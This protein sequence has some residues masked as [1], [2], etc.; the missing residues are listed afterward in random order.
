MPSNVQ[1][2]PVSAWEE[3]ILLPTYPVPAP[4]PNP[5]FLDKRVNQG[6][7]G[8]VYPNPFTDRLSNEKVERPY[9]AVF[10]ENEYLQLILLPEIGGRIFA[11]LDKTNGFNFFYR[12]HVIKPALIGLLGAWISG[13]VEF[14][15]PQHHR[16]STFMRVDH[17]IEEHPDGSRTVWLSDHEPMDRTRGMVGICLHPGR[18][19][20][21]F[22]VRL[23]NCTPF[24]Q[25]F[26]WWVNTAVH[27]HDQ[28]QVVFPPDVTAVTD[29]SKRA[30]CHFPVARGAYYGVD[31]TGVDIS[32][33]R[34]IPVAASYF[35]TESRYDFF[36]GYD[37]KHDAGV[38]HVADHHISPGKKMFTWGT[39][40]FG[41][42]WERN[43]TDADGPYIEL[44]AGMYTD[45]QPDFS[46]I[47]PY[48]RKTFSQFWYPVQ[49]IGPA[50]DANC[51]LAVNLETGDRSARVGVCVT[52]SFPRAAISLAA[53][54]R[55]LF[56][57]KVDLAP[58]A[59]FVEQVD[60]PAGLVEGDLLLR[61]CDEAGEEL[62]RYAPQV[63][64]HK[65]LPEAMAPAPPPEEIHSAEELFLTGLHLEQYKHPTQEPE[66]YWER[67]LA[68]D[69][70]DV[71]CNNALGLS[72]L[73]RG[74]LVQAEHHF[75]QAIRTLT[76]RNPSPRDGEPYYNLGL[77]LKHQGRLDEAYDA[78]YKAIWSY[79]WQAAGYLALAELDGLQGHLAD[80]LAHLDRSLSTNALNLVARDLKAAILRRLSRYP[81]AEALLRETMREDLLDYGSR[82]ELALLSRAQGHGPAAEEQLRELAEIMRGDEGVLQAQRHLDLAF[83]YAGAGLWPE[84]SEVLARLV[85]HKGA[86]GP[87]Y[88]MVLY[89]MGYF[90]HRS[91]QESQ[92]QELY[93]RAAAMPPD[94]CFPVR[95]EELAILQHVVCADPQDA[96][97]QYYLGNLLYDKKRYDEAI[98]AW[99]AACRLDP[100]FSISWRNLGLACY[101]VRRDP[102]RAVACYQQAFEANPG[103][104][105]LL[106][107]MD[108][109]L[110]RQGVLGAARLARLEAHPDLVAQRDDLTAER[111]ALYNQL[112]QPER[113][114]EIILGRRFHPWE[115]GEGLVSGQYVSAHLL[116]GQGALDD[117]RAEQALAH[118]EAARTY[119]ESLGEGQ[120]PWATEAH[121]DYL[122]GL[123]REALGDGEG[124]RACFE[125]AA[126]ARAGLSAE[127]YYQ[128]LALRKLGHV[129]AARRR[130]QELLD[131]ATGRLEETGRPGF[132]T[133]V[134]QFVFYDP[135]PRTPERIAYTFL[136]G[137]AQRGLGRDAEAMAS[138]S[139]VL[140]L[141]PNHLGAQEE[142]RR[143][144]AQEGRAH[145]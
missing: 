43:L 54:D 145:E 120:W 117:G 33:P 61:V 58:G 25:T 36:G 7:T 77:A 17:L 103:D 59:P 18:A 34:N 6:A 51:R 41:R 88:P 15:W 119:P 90:A 143:P 19:L 109:L 100:G 92:A 5:M 21:E 116:L 82:N 73:R 139:E 101:N 24:P 136:L 66:P 30:M 98:Q 70:G 134:P 63:A 26:L 91:G 35:V 44:M 141:D 2:Q 8:R 108:Q 89:A 4:D 56:A 47:Q 123:A 16:P 132:Q 138:F 32:W 135:D 11:G 142:L 85:E 133:S 55:V 76:R 3:T 67:A 127:C 37:H 78:L 125:R 74:N 99:E 22:K 140:A 124:S 53:G 95:L 9:R 69:P 114:L 118:F 1:S 122:A 38:I 87:V 144:S 110:K 31:L 130:L 75:R 71:R 60:L 93:R 115:G 83:D 104:A 126:E 84:A 57:R 50:K 79:A 20:I 13:G 113:A 112:R 29:H 97:A 12:Q 105:R 81:E 94:Y 131:H 107:E 48:E 52:E 68:M 62:I 80:A 111:A 46:W 86:A 72:H 128:A 40:S 129:E 14:N 23:Y 106:S 28:Y 49:K 39:G 45:N 102:G 10:V 42:A 96:R 27:M 65:P 64:E 137:L 121:L